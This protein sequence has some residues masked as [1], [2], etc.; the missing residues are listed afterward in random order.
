MRANTWHLD[1]LTY[2]NQTSIAMVPHDL[3]M[4]ATAGCPFLMRFHQQNCRHPSKRHPLLSSPGTIQT[5]PAIAAFRLEQKF[6]CITHHN[7]HNQSGLF[8]DWNPI[9]S[10][11][12]SQL[13]TE[14]TSLLGGIQ[15]RQQRGR[16]HGPRPV[17]VDEAWRRAVR[18]SRL[19]A[20][21]N[22]ASAGGLP[23]RDGSK[24]PNS[25]G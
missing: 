17:R 16:R 5:L 15:V 6:Y 21:R 4:G 1:T 19:G 24:A 7:P 14:P 10:S 18:G 11:S 20:A 12:T 25:G 13:D 22:A 8:T 3:L 2:I 9:S 23:P